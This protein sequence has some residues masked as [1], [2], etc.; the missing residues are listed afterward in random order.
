[1]STYNK[2]LLCGD[3]VLICALIISGINYVAYV[4][5]NF[6]YPS[7][8]TIGIPV[9]SSYYF[10]CYPYSWIIVVTVLAWGCALV[11]RKRTLLEDIVIL[12]AFAALVTSSYTVVAVVA[13]YLCNRALV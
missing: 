8:S 3:L 7:K 9:L 2:I 6:G 4:D 12:W 5:F 13:I 1:M 11:W 10:E